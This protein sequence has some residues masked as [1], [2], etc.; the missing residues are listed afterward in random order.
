MSEQKF[1]A[2]RYY[3][4]LC[5]TSEFI[6]EL[7]KVLSTG[8]KSDV[9][10]DNNGNIL[11][12]P[13]VLQSKNWD[14]V[15]PKPDKTTLDI[16]LDNMTSDDYKAKI[17]NQ[18]KQISDTVILKTTT[19]PV[20]AAA[21]FDDL[22]ISQDTTKDSL[23]MYLEIYKPAFLADPEKYPLDCERNGVVPKLITKDMYKESFQ[24][25]KRIEEIITTNANA[26][27]CSLTNANSK[28]TK[29]VTFTNVK[30]AELI[31]TKIQSIYGAN[32]GAA[33]FYFPTSPGNASSEITFNASKIIEIKQK[34][35]ELYTLIKTTF[36]LDDRTYQR[37][38]TLSFQVAMNMDNTHTITMVAVTQYIMY[39]IEAGKSYTIKGLNDATLLSTLIPEY[40]LDGIYTPL[41]DDS[42]SVDLET[43]TVITFNKVI[44]GDI[45]ENGNIVIRFDIQKDSN[46]TITERKAIANN[47]YMLM[48]LF[49]VINEEGNA[50]MENA[51]DN[52]GELIARKSHA[53]DW[54]KLSWYQDFEDIYVDELDSDSGIG[55]VN[56]GT[57]HVPLETVGL[58][59]DTKIRYW[60]N[61]NNDRFSLVVMGNPSLDY[62][63]NRHITGAC[64][65]GKIDSFEKSI[66]DIAGNFALFTSSSTEPCNTTMEIQ[67]KFHT[68]EA[69]DVDN[70][71]SVIC[72]N[73]TREYHVLIPE[74]RHFNKNVWPKYCIKDANE[75]MSE[76]KTVHQIYYESDNEA[77]ISIHDAFDATHTLYVGYLYYEED[78]MFHS[79][80]DRDMFG[81]VLDVSKTNTYGL[82]TSDGVTSIMMYHT[83]SKAYYQKHQMMFTTTEEYMSKVMYGKSSYTGEYYADRIKVTHTNDGPRGM[84]NDILVIDSSS[85]YPLDELVIN[86][87]FNKSKEEYEE[88]FVYFPITAP[89]SPLSDSPNARY[90]LAIKK[91]EVE[92]AFSDEDKVINIAADQLGL[93]ASEIWNNI[94][95]DIYPAEETNNGCSVL[96]EI[97]QDSAWTEGEN[98]HVPTNFNSIALALIPTKEYKGITVTPEGTE[99][100][101]KLTP[102]NAVL[103]AGS[104]VGTLDKAY[105]NLTS[106][107]LSPS[108]KLY[109]GVSDEPINDIN[110]NAYIKVTPLKDGKPIT[111]STGAQYEYGIQGVPYH[112][113]LD[114]IPETNEI[115]LTNA[116][117]NKF[118]M[119]YSIKEEVGKAVITKYACLPLAGDVNPN[120]LLQ[121]PCTV[122]TTIA[123]GMGKLLTAQNIVAPYNSNVI[124]AFEAEAGWTVENI[125]VNGEIQSSTK[126]EVNGEMKDGYTISAINK[127][128][129]IEVFF[130]KSVI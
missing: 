24:E 127:D 110:K 125:K 88:T 101:E 45:N 60:I 28:D 87:D 56:D 62:A 111:N 80:I 46:S 105:V 69:T 71:F 79:G 37:L 68:I 64:Y 51:Y 14:I 72:A 3:E 50:P 130:T 41:P 30:E 126:V 53:S 55:N 95:K 35:N 70:A 129:K 67:K 33:D 19:T 54:S 91:S 22:S 40:K 119:L 49:D 74:G 103:A 7:S 44:E 122:S 76:V 96:W 10:K 121:Y 115:E 102:E 20:Q 118:L 86:K 124:V 47:H 2:Y 82:N 73:G 5:S 114:A 77:V 113:V 18:L 59:G 107:T 21:I 17:E 78:I 81:N 39:K 97:V 9:V 48:R 12:D 108:D 23:T 63:R 90:G 104:K 66:N 29:S 16:D 128:T 84:L 4:G 109:Y 112:S 75:N 83:Q 120:S 89:F 106:F 1:K 52:N 6:K 99:T 34:D 116:S 26:D 32:V 123:A 57:V 94:D 100:F 42:Y 92:P 11:V 85:L 15:Y 65:C 36:N 38:N 31:T 8:V 27:V 117:P 98:G 61:T 93:I 58:N 13:F 43:G 25:T